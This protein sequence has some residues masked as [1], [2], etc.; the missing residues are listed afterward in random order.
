MRDL[1]SERISEKR[2]LVNRRR[3]QG[4]ELV[5]GGVSFRV[6]AP[7]RRRVDVVLDEGA[8]VEAM[9]A[10]E[11]GHWAV[12]LPG[13][14]AGTR[15]QYRLDGGE[16]S[17]P[18]PAGCFMPEGPHGPSEVVDPDQFRWTDSLWTGLPLHGQVIYELHIATLSFQTP[19]RASASSLFFRRY[20][21]QIVHPADPLGTHAFVVEQASSL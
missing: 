20:P 1:S 5:D 17:F 8:V 16:A 4:A 21:L 9:T 6:W 13:I 14:G 19:G 11:D 12:T 10:V 3:A 7:G 18:D 2:K 15:Y